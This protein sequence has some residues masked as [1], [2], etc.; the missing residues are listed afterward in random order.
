VGEKEEEGGWLKL[1][2]HSYSIVA[3]EGRKR[4]ESESETEGPVSISLGFGGG[5]K[6]REEKKRRELLR[7][8]RHKGGR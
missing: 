6:R 7:G 8:R 3:V 5:G 4:R 2:R 1:T